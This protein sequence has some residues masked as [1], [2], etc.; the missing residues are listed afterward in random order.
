MEFPEIIESGKRFWQTE[1]SGSGSALPKGHGI[2]NA[3]FYARMIHW[4]MTLAQTNAFLYWWLW[5]NSSAADFPGAL[6][7]ID[8][9][10]IITSKRLYAMGQYSRF[11]RPGWQRIDC[12]VSPRGGIYSS[13]YKNPNTKEIAIVIINETIAHFSVLLD[14]TGAKFDQ[15]EI[16]RTSENESMKKTGKQ[17]TSHNS[18]EVI[19]APMSITTYY[20]KVK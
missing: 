13:A 14:L 10:E 9:D 11:I 20:G 19:L 12:D 8:D 1:V 15:L 5:T 7:K 18:A 16:W 2:H 4:D 6:I 17:Q 3:L